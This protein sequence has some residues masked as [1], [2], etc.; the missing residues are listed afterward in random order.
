MDLAQELDDER[1]GNAPTILRLVKSYIVSST[2]GARYIPCNKGSWE[3]DMLD[4]DDWHEV[5]RALED[6]ELDPNVGTDSFR[7]SRSTSRSTS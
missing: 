6:D 4:A 3:Y 5:E 2:P 1:K 7:V